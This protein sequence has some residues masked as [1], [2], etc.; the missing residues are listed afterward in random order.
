[1]PPP[2]NPSLA[3]AHINAQQRLRLIV[4][5]AVRGAWRGLPGYDDRDVDA[6]LASALPAVEAGRRQSVA[7]TEAFLARAV[8]RQPNG[9]DVDRIVAAIRNGADPRQVYRRPFVTTWT[10]LGSG[11]DWS[12][13]VASGE[14]RAVGMAATDVQLAMRDTLRDVGN[15]DEAIL[16]YQRVPDG[17]ACDLCLQIAGQRYTTDELQPVHN[18]CGCSV[19]VITATERGAFSGNYGNDP[20]LTREGVV[21]VREHGELGPVLVNGEH[22]FTQLH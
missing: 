14:A 13:A 18:N 6:F 12:D 19:D 9:A 15:A 3:N 7:L 8:R 2:V 4:A 21:E 1:M 16:G 10:A 5:E 22:D 11:A 17:K 20:I